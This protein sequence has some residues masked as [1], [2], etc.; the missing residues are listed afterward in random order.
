VLV[1]QQ[2]QGFQESLSHCTRHSFSMALA[3]GKAGQ[4][5]QG[6]EAFVCMPCG[7]RLL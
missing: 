1:M 2:K 5:K 3:Q 6:I 7:A 4:E